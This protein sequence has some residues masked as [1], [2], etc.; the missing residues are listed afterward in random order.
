MEILA[1]NF[2]KTLISFINFLIGL[3][4]EFTSEI[5]IYK[6]VAEA[7]ISQDK[8]KLIEQF[9]IHCLPFYK[10]IKRIQEL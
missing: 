3:R 1:E 10:Q 2:N 9:M 4:S 8:H 6:K 7:L 5:K